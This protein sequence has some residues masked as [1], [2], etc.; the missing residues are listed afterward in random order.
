[1]GALALQPA[2]LRVFDGEVR[3]Q[4]L[5][6]GEVLGYG[7]PKKVRTVI[8]RHVDELLAHGV[9]TQSESKPLPGSAGGRP[10]RSFM[11][12]EAQA[13]LVAMFSRTDRAAE[14]RRQIVQVFLAWRHGKLAPCKNPRRASAASLPTRRAGRGWLSSIDKLAASCP[15]EIRWMKDAL[16]ARVLSQTEILSEFNARIAV[17][18]HKPISKGAF[19][20][21]S[22]AASVEVS[23]LA[24]DRQIT[25]E[26]IGAIGQGGEAEAM[27][28]AALIVRERLISSVNMLGGGDIKAEGTAALA[29]E[30][31]N[32]ILTAPRR[33]RRQAVSA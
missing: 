28:A 12:N 20:R 19:S 10:E 26:I 14:A 24:A 29:L 15:D 6:L 3:V 23:R 1:M 11:L 13:V 25:A 7:N 8:R 9:L 27:K 32:A 21:Y 16:A 4:D 2:D 5:R 31:L 33:R 22:V 30:R 17:H 18:G